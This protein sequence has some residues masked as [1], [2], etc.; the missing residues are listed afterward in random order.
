MRTCHPPYPQI[1]LLV[2]DGVH[3][4]PG[5][6]RGH[7]PKLPLGEHRSRKA[8]KA[9]SRAKKVFSSYLNYCH[10]NLILIKAVPSRLQL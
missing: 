2:S 10:P 8:R 6:H 3:F 9:A 5:Q 1:N 4:S 7:S